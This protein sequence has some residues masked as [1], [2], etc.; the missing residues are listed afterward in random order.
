MQFLPPKGD[1]ASELGGLNRVYH[2]GQEAPFP[3]LNGGWGV[4]ANL[5][6][7]E[8]VSR[9]SVAPIPTQSNCSCEMVERRFARMSS[10]E[11]VSSSETAGMESIAVSLSS[12]KETGR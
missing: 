6:S 1:R 8:M 11:E 12:S 3:F 7:E 4:F 9:T 5:P 2:P 10:A